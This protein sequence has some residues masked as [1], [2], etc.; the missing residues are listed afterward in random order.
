MLCAC[1]SLKD[2]LLALFFF[3]FLSSQLLGL[4]KFY[5]FIFFSLPSIL[6]FLSL[7]WSCFILGLPQPHAAWHFWLYKYPVVLSKYENHPVWDG[8]PEQCF[9]GLAPL[10]LCSI[11]FNLHLNLYAISCMF[12]KFCN[13]TYAQW[14]PQE[15]ASMSHLKQKLVQ[16]T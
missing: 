3:F 11:C 9:P 14:L 1:S 12:E 10:W 13:F 8:S 16:S 15:S 5:F 2:L 4:L 7:F 6:L